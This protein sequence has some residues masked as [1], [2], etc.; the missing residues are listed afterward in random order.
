MSYSKGNNLN[1]YSKLEIKKTI[2]HTLS[3]FSDKA[4]FDERTTFCVQLGS[5]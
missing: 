5:Q 1:L 3:S 2:F 4:K